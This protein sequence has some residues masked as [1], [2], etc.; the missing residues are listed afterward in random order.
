MIRTP[1][2][3]PTPGG[4]G[5]PPGPGGP[6]GNPAGKPVGGG[7]SSPKPAA[8]PSSSKPAPTAPVAPIASGAAASKP[9]SPASAQPPKS[10]TSKSVSESPAAQNPAK[11]AKPGLF[12]NRNV[13][14]GAAGAGALVLVVA[15]LLW[16]P[17]QPSP[18]RLNSEPYV[19]AKFAA[20]SAMDDLPFSQQREYMDILADKDDALLAAYKD[21]RLTDQE[22]RRALQLG[23]YDKHLDRMEKFY[24][25]P[26]MRRI[27]YIDSK[28]LGKK[29]K[30]AAVAAGAP[31]AKK[32]KDEEKSDDMT[33]L[34][35]EE[36]DRDDS[37]EEQDIKR[38]PADVRQKW[39][40]YRA[41]VAARKDFYKERERQAKEAAE[42]KKSNP[43]ANPKPA[44]APDQGQQPPAPASPDQ[45]S[46]TTTTPNT[47][48]ANR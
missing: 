13:V 4:S 26:P 38:W 23:W 5:N 29:I 44:G 21:G 9:Q 18:P 6:G 30:A 39:T 12:A 45:S 2:S 43:S 24:D 31:G 48:D 10:P 36:I 8:Y 28:V 47:A 19:I 17:W 27:E 34:K 25:R 16:R 35:P 40:E 41:A 3:N 1:S 14:Y 11:P 46:A 22:Y 15:L 32:P 42:A 7:A 37:N 33:A 20:S